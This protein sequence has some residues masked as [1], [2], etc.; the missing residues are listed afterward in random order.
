MGYY[1][2]LGL[3]GRGFSC[4]HQSIKVVLEKIDCQ[5]TACGGRAW[6]RGNIRILHSLIMTQP[7]SSQPPGAKQ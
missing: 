7:K 4:R 6:G 3:K 2:V 5:L 1:M